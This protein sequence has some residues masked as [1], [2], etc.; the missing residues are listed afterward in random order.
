MA[1]PSC[2]ESL[3]EQQSQCRAQAK[4]HVLRGRTAKPAI[5][6]RQVTRRPVPVSSTQISG[7]VGGLGSWRG[8]HK[9]QAGRHHQALLR[10]RH[11]HVDAP[12][13]HFEFHAADRGDAVDHEQGG[14][15]GGI[16]GRADGRNVVDHARGGVDLHDQDSLDAV[17]RV[18]MEPGFDR[19][20]VD[21]APPVGSETLNLEPE[22]I[23]LLT[24]ASGK[25]P[26]FKHQDVVTP[27]QGVGEGGFPGAMAIGDV[28]IN[29]TCGAEYSGEVLQA[30]LR[31]FQ[32]VVG[33]DIDGRPVHGLEHD[34]GNV[35]RAG[36]GQKLTTACERSRTSDGANRI[37]PAGPWA[38]ILRHTQELSFSRRAPSNLTPCNAERH[39]ATRTAG[40][41]V[42]DRERFAERN[43]GGARPVQ[44]STECAKSTAALSVHPYPRWIDTSSLSLIQSAA[45]KGRQNFRQRIG[46]AGDFR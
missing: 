6:V 15:T 44:V 37:Q 39:C 22:Q 41:D 4:Q 9:R 43:L 31:S 5:V 16:D 17:R 25:T 3:F 14:M 12:A 11:R 30:L 13:I 35:G 1:S 34:F 23:A 28:D 21:G 24:P 38:V 32:Q 46:L 40:D 42:A 18:S 33:V 26:A 10:A 7:P 19:R 36:N 8:S 2:L 20:G 45:R 27:R 29:R